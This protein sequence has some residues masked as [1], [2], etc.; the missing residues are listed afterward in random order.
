MLLSIFVFNFY[1]SA[2]RN[3]FVAF[4]EDLRANLTEFE[5]VKRVLQFFPTTGRTLIFIARI[6]VQNVTP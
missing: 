3:S 4:R 2:T 5:N 6:F 1:L